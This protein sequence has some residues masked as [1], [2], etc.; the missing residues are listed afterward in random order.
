MVSRDD[1]GENVVHDGLVQV[2]DPQIPSPTGAIPFRIQF[3]PDGL[4]R[5]RDLA[6]DRAVAHS[7][8]RERVFGVHIVEIQDIQV[9]RIGASSRMERSTT[10]RVVGFPGGMALYEERSSK[11]THMRLLL[12]MAKIHIHTHLGAMCG[13]VG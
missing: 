1:L 7:R 13:M 10:W 9:N 11:H 5:L 2:V 12:T 8:D 3:G 6:L 4:P